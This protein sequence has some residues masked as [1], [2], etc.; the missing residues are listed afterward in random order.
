M[1]VS[2]FPDK[3]TKETEVLSGR[4]LGRLLAFLTVLRPACLSPLQV[5]G[6][7]LRGVRGRPG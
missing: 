3:E 5:G 1:L 7:R 6:Q 4:E 2:L